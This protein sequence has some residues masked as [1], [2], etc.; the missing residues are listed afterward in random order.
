MSSYMMVEIPQQAPKL[1]F[2]GSP[3]ITKWIAWPCNPQPE[4][5]S[6][7]PF[8]TLWWGVWE[9]VCGSWN[10]DRKPKGAEK[11]GE[12]LACAGQP[13]MDHSPLQRG[14]QG[15]AGGLK[16]P[17]SGEPNHTR[18][19][20]RVWTTSGLSRI[21]S[22][23]GALKGVTSQPCKILPFP[24]SFGD[25]PSGHESHQHLHVNFKV[26]VMKRKGP[27][28]QSISVIIIVI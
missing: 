7:Q 28:A 5:S 27:V 18:I 20:L 6:H 17:S 25:L 14:D 13:R 1:F 24:G 10:R 8:W 16:T 11:Q 2:R 21:D 9:K 12:Q 26:A 19:T 22:F 3:H 15:K 4:R 23:L